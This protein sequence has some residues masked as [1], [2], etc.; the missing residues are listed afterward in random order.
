[1]GR[2]Q[3]CRQRE[4]TLT[5][6]ILDFEASTPGN[7]DLGKQ[8]S[9]AL[10]ATLSGQEGFT[11]VDRA[12]MSRTLLENELNMTGLVDADH[13]T[14]IGKLVG[15]KILVT[16]KIFPLDKQLYFTVKLVGTET[17]R[18]SGV[19]LKGDKDGD[20]G[21]LM[22]KLADKVAARLREAGPNLV[23]ST[24]AIED[25][26]PALKKRTGRQESCRR[27]R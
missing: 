5:V 8:I 21:E 11:L 12:S 14:K 10:A 1:M 23:A 9:E 3:R 4:S 16:G 7:P 24:D 22:L 26:L 13:A 15:A 20:V 2:P 19:L 25:P 6:A 18:I 27:S 17:S